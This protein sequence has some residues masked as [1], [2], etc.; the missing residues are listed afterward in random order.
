MGSTKLVDRHREVCEARGQS[1][2]TSRL[3]GFDDPQP[4]HT[5][6]ESDEPSETSRRARWR[7]ARRS[8]SPR[9]SVVS[10]GATAST[11]LA[12][13][14]LGSVGLRVA[15]SAWTSER[16]PSAMPIAGS[17]PRAW[18]G[19]TRERLRRGCRWCE[20]RARARRPRLARR[21]WRLGGEARQR[22]SGAGPDVDHPSRRA[23][24]RAMRGGWPERH[25]LRGRSRER[26]PS[27]LTA[28][29]TCLRADA[30]RK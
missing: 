26:A 17:K 29:A 10:R 21:W 20:G 16:S 28:P 9:R 18:T 3:V 6:P 11:E 1:R 27:P 24:G 30:A 25:R 5:S 19:A 2:P 7:A 13:D 14:R 12:L 4:R 23:P 22:D 8:V 15:S